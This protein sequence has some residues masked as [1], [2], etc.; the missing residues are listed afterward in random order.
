M[1]GLRSPRDESAAPDCA[2]PD[3]ADNASAFRP[4]RRATGVDWRTLAAEQTELFRRDMESLRVIPPD[5][6]VAATE[7]IEQVS[8]AVHRLLDRGTAYRIDGDI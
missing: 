7:V 6:Y 4:N 2:G 5:N 8:E 3:N 1:L